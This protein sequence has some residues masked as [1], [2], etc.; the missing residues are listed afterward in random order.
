MNVGCPDASST[1]A[2]AMSPIAVGV[3]ENIANGPGSFGIRN[4]VGV[5]SAYIALAV[6]NPVRLASIAVR[7]H[8]SIRQ[9]KQFLSFQVFASE[10]FADHS[11]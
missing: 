11:S 7:D 10:K 6:I 1:G 5:R 9:F 3:Q 4:G 2:P 8:W